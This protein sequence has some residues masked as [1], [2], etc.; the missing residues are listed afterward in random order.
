M[1]A[2]I[3]AGGKQ[4][5]VRPGDVIEVELLKESGEEVDLDPI[6]VV[7][8]DGSVVSKRSELSEARVTAKVL[9]EVKG[10]KIEMFKYKNKSGYQHHQGHR[11][12]YSAVEV[13]GI[14]VDGVTD[15]KK[16]SEKSTV[17]KKVAE[18]AI[19]GQAAA[20]KP[21]AKKAT[22]SK[23]TA[24]KTAAAKKPATKA[25]TASKAAATKTAAAK[26]PAAKPAA[27]KATAA[28]PKAAKS[29][30]PKP[31]SGADKPASAK[32]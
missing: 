31:K 13:T 24:T 1:Y 29:T 16:P 2:V 7:K 21:A 19:A 30:A 23:A 11:Q 4:T 5:K 20:N 32:E 6:L 15:T 28:K 18:K 26:K 9:G 22:A 17:G 8:D 14:Q 10:R 3:R 12:R 25:S 27:K